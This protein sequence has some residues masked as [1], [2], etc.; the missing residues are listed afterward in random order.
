MTYWPREIL[1]RG[2]VLNGLQ[3]GPA[4]VVDLVESAA[5]EF[6]LERREILVAGRLLCVIEERR[7]DGLWW[8]RPNIVAIWWKRPIVDDWSRYRLQFSGGN[9]A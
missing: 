3:H 2:A 8:T 9:A 4:K 7:R 1:A 5:K 6:A